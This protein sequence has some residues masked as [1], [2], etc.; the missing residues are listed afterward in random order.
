MRVFLL[1][2]MFLLGCD[3]SFPNPAAVKKDGGVATDVDSV[4]DAHHPPT[5]DAELD[6]TEVDGQVDA[7]AQSLDG[8]IPQDA[9]GDVL[10]NP[11]VITDVSVIPRDATPSVIDAVVVEPDAAPPPAPTCTVNDPALLCGAGCYD[12]QGLIVCLWTEQVID[13]RCY[14]DYDGD[15]LDPAQGDCDDGNPDTAWCWDQPLPPNCTD[16]NFLVELE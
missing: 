6:A 15:G 2:L 3:P 16:T 7:A 14:H 1:S 10:D 8:E 11:D 9:G 5:L 13:D 4:V 12:E